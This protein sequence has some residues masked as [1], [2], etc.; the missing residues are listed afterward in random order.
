MKEKSTSLKNP[1]LLI[2]KTRMEKA[3]Q[4]YETGDCVSHVYE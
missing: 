1:E 3:R 4:N 2:Y